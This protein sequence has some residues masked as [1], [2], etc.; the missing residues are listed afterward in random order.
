MI[1]TKDREII[2][3]LIQ[4]AEKK[5]DSEMVPMIVL[6][7]DNYPAAHFRAAIIVSFLFSLGLYF[8]P[9][10]IINPIYF[11]WIQ[12]PGLL[13]GYFLANIPF[14]ARLMITKQE[15]EFEVTQRA[16]E[17][18]FEH[19]LHTTNQHNGV[20]IFISIL[21]KKIKI[22]TD[23]GVRKKIEQKIWD[24]VIYN[25]TKNVNN[26]GFVE[27]LK[28]TIMATSDILENYFPATEEFKKNELRDDI[29]IE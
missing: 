29:I 28:S 25:F 20:L 15:I 9:L 10:S 12:I 27:A 2:K 22:I 6:R 26:S 1:S 21:E 17:A 24:E 23:V 13:L 3:E 19:N 4:D 14:V 18:F 8:S 11:L 16:I 7:S 5:S